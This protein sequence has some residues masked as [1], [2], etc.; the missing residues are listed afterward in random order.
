MRYPTLAEWDAM[1]DTRRPARR[2]DITGQ[3]F[4]RL[5]AI[6]PVGH[7]GHTN[8]VWLCQCFCGEPVKVPTNCLRSGNTRS[9][10]CL[11]R[12]YWK[13]K[14]KHIAKSGVRCEP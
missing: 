2:I 4:G 12:E 10:G 3:V 1:R 14:R 9:C 5:I 8:I 11:R 6:R 7:T 13:T